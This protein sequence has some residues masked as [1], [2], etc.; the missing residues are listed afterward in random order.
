MVKQMDL[1][2]FGHCTNTGACAVE[3]PAKVPLSAIATLQ[4][5]FLLAALLPDPYAE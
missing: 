1:E 2:G 3:C 4:R 5:E